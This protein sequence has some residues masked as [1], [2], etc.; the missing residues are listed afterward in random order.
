MGIVLAVL[1]EVRRVF[2][3]YKDVK[4]RITISPGIP[5]ENST[6]SFW[7]HPP[8]NI[9]LYQSDISKNTEYDI[10]ILGSGISGLSVAKTIL[11]SQKDPES[12]RPKILMLEAREACSGA[13]GRYG[14]IKII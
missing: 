7:M 14:D 3:L 13:T 12:D 6:K 4:A 2:G 10:V 5:V 8:S 9:A 11:D 1:G